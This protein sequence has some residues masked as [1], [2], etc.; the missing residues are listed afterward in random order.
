DGWLLIP[1]DHP[2]L[3]P[4]VIRGLLSAASEVTDKS[5]FVPTHAGRRGHPTWLRWSHG[6]AVRALPADQGL[7][8][9][10][11]SSAAEILE[12]PWPTDEVLLDLDTPE[13]YAHI[14]KL[15]RSC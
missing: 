1:A 8:A 10:I 12:M 2:T 13:D 6:A 14:C 4:D 3:G 7:N 5:I 9:Y 11:R 15:R